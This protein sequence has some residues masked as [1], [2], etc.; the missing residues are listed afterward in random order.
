MTASE[1]QISDGD[2]EEYQHCGGL[3]DEST[4]EDPHGMGSGS[5][6]NE[7]AENNVGDK[8]VEKDN[9]AEVGFTLKNTEKWLQHRI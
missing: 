2:F 9:G 6:D 4:R 1:R 7:D 8:N 5:M 3:S